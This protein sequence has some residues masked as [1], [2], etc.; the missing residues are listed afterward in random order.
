MPKETLLPCC[1][2]CDNAIEVYDAAIVYV[3]GD[4]KALAHEDCVVALDDDL[5]FEDDFDEDEDL[6]SLSSY[7]PDVDPEDDD[8]F[9]PNY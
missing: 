9:D 3:E 2:L 4:Y 7:D 8:E 6:E 1:P 5:G